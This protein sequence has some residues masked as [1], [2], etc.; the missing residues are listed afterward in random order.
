M[1]GIFLQQDWAR[2]I[3]SALKTVFALYTLRRTELSPS[4]YRWFQVCWFLRFVLPVEILN[5]TSE[6]FSSERGCELISKEPRFLVGEVEGKGEDYQVYY[7][8]PAAHKKATHK[9]SL[10][11]W[12]N[13]KALGLATA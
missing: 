11:L 10:K 4:R 9:V 13:I 12:K 5:A 7:T 8:V 3:Y 2:F 1:V 6:K